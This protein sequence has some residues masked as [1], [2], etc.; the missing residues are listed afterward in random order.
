MIDALEVQKRVLERETTIGADHAERLLEIETQMAA[1]KQELTTLQTQLRR[2]RRWSSRIR[3]LQTGLESKGEPDTP[4]AGKP[5]E[6]QKE[7][8]SPGSGTRCAAG[9]ARDDPCL[10]SM[11]RSWAKSSLHG[12]GFRWA[13]W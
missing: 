1:A 8:A 11:R 13:R 10:A 9:R 12:P 7:L 6:S 2:K 5:G 3:E 4:T